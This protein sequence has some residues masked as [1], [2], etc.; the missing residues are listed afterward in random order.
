MV[1]S[2][3]RDMSS[4]PIEQHC[5]SGDEPLIPMPPLTE[6]AL[7]TA[8][9][10]LDLAAAVRFENEFHAAW[11][12]AVQ[13]DS[14]VPMHTFLHRWGVFVALRRNP[15]RAARLEELEHEVA[16]AETIEAAREAAAEITALLDTARREVLG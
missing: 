7:R 8:V 14:T 1:Q 10:T 13:M 4:Q 16:L 5:T 9:S 15:A 11:Q 2:E 6:Q 12:E 3:V